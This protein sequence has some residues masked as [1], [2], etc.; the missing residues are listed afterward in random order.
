MLKGHYS[1]PFIKRATSATKISPCILLLKDDEL[2]P[3]KI[4]IS[5]QDDDDDLNLEFFLSMLN[6]QC[7]SI[8]FLQDCTSNNNE[9]KIFTCIKIAYLNSNRIH[10]ATI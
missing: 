6:F 2:A 8:R 1:Y 9:L 3:L 5:N 10:V 4:M 7:T